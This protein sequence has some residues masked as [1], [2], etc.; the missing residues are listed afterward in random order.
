L[1][2]FQ[3]VCVVTYGLSKTD[4]FHENSNTYPVISVARE[5]VQF[6]PSIPIPFLVIVICAVSQV[7][8]YAFNNFKD[9]YSLEFFHE[10]RELIHKYL[11]KWN[12]E[13]D[14]NLRSESLYEGKN[15]LVE[16]YWAVPLHDSFCDRVCDP[17]RKEEEKEMLKSFIHFLMNEMF[18]IAEKIIYRNLKEEVRKALTPRKRYLMRIINEGKENPNGKLVRVRINKLFSER[19]SSFFVVFNFQLGCAFSLFP[20]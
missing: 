3:I 15:R 10:R 6:D 18:R 16:A 17:S 7:V 1:L 14:A 11:K 5:I 13:T 12:T 9:K 19:L 4:L 8:A 20:F 2:K